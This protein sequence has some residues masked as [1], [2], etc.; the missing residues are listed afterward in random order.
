MQLQWR[1][2]LVWITILASSAWGFA[3]PRFEPDMLDFGSIVQ[4]G[5]LKTRVVVYNSRKTNLVLL[6]AEAPPGCEVFVSKKTLAPGDTATL[7]MTYRPKQAG[8]FK[9]SIRILH[10]Q[11][12]QPA[13]LKF[14]GSVATL[15]PDIL[16]NCVSFQP[17]DGSEMVTV[18]G[19][20][21]YRAIFRDAETGQPIREASILFVSK[22][23]VRKQEYSTTTGLLKA[24][25]PTGPYAL[26]IS[27]PGYETLMTEQEMMRSQHSGTFLLSKPKPKDPPRDS[28]PTPI[29][30]LEIPSE[31]APVALSESLDAKWYRPNNLVFLVDVSGSMKDPDKLPL[32]REAVN[33]MVQHIRPQ[34]YVSIITYAETVQV[35]LPPTTGADK[36]KIRTMLDSLKAAGVTAGSA[37]LRKAYDVVQESWIPDGN[38][39]V[40]L[41]TDGAFR[42]SGKDR[43]MVEAEGKQSPVL[44]VV[45]FGDQETA[46][47]MLEGISKLGKGSFIRI[48]SEAEAK[49]LLMNEIRMRSKRTEPIR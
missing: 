5:S 39:Q 6:R 45:A 37:G 4:A 2:F 25:I 35:V 3:Q 1:I 13:E 28:L 16:T 14:E 22:S 9:G 47:N 48:R 20:V 41:A 43:K 40:I 7:R 15:L 30:T 44:S 8:S 49:A 19:M 26:V 34:D 38:N 42:I 46:L 31:P 32:L 10:N 11:S 36:Q 27:A 18:P 24:D 29:A 33:S 21:P 23:S 17:K 12:E